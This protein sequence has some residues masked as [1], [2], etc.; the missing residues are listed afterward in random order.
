MRVTSVKKG[1][2]FV[3][4]KDKSIENSAYTASDVTT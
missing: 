4:V 1:D 2:N 3:V